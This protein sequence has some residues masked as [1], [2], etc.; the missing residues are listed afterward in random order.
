VVVE[1]TDKGLLTPIVKAFYSLKSNETFT[2][3]VVDLSQSQDAIANIE[4]PA[5]WGFDLKQITGV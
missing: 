5:R 1:Q 4:D 3:Q 2:P